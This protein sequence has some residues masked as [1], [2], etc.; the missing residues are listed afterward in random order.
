MMTDEATVG[1][2]RAVAPTFEAFYSSSWDAVYR[3][4]AVAVGEADLAREA[5]DEAMTRAFERWS[6]VSGMENPQGWVYRVAVNW[7]RSFLRR[8]LVGLRKRQQLDWRIEDV[9]VPDPQVVE[10]VGKLPPHQ[11]DVI[12]ARF[13]LD[14]SE[15]DT[16]EAFNV[17][18]GTVKSR[19]NRALLVLKEDLS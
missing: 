10:A 5:V 3:A 4:V 9:E 11:R 17:A 19:V 6:S 14:M 16:A 12:I 1:E 13:L 2:G 7:S 15:K 8:R 18:Q